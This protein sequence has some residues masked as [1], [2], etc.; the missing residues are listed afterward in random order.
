MMNQEIEKLLAQI[1]LQVDQ[2]IDKLNTNTMVKR[3]MKKVAA[4]QIDHI[5]G[6]VSKARTQKY[7]ARLLNNPV[8][9]KNTT[10]QKQ[11]GAAYWAVKTA[12]QPTAAEKEAMVKRLIDSTCPSMTEK[13]KRAITDLISEQCSTYQCDPQ[14]YWEIFQHVDAACWIGLLQ[15]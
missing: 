10:L 8:I 15:E 14:K 5:P 1:K 7:V 11:I 2:A 4:D 12:I 6:L 3:G 13:K 9:R